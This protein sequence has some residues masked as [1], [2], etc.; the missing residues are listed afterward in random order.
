[1]DMN[2]IS[3]YIHRRLSREDIRCTRR[4]L[5]SGTAA[6]V[7]RCVRPCVCLF[8]CDMEGMGGLFAL[9]IRGHLEPLSD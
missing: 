4:L 2:P 8:A 1:M 9:C 6:G 5:V 3:S 7:A